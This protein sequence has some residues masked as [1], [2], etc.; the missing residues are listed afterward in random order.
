MSVRISNKCPIHKK[1]SN[2]MNF[3]IDTVNC[4][5]LMTIT[6]SLWNLKIT[7]SVE[8]ENHNITIS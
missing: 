5:I 6:S 8:F 2:Q 4:L 3:R 1:Y 7:I